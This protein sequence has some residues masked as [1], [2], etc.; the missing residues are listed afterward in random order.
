M[1]YISKSVHSQPIGNPTSLV[2]L[3]FS[4][5]SK[6][7]VPDIGTYEEHKKQKSTGGPLLR[8]RRSSTKPCP[9]YY[10]AQLS[11][12]VFCSFTHRLSIIIERRICLFHLSPTLLLRLSLRFGTPHFSP[13]PDSRGCFPPIC[14]VR[15]TKKPIAPPLLKCMIRHSSFRF[16]SEDHKSRG[17]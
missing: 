9:G 10:S 4:G 17:S 12:R 7:A 13:Q 1:Q 3:G 6:G 5:R 8:A 16:P 14:S 11:G 2:L 15:L